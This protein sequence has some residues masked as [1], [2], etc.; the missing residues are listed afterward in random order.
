[1]GLK[2][3][4]QIPAR[5]CTSQRAIN[6][7]V[8]CVAGIACCLLGVVVLAVAA[9]VSPD[10][11]LAHLPSRYHIHNIVSLLEQFRLCDMVIGCILCLEGLIF[12]RFKDRLAG[13]CTLSPCLEKKDIWPEPHMRAQLLS[14]R[15]HRAIVLLIVFLSGFLAWMSL[16]PGHDWGGDFAA[17]I[18]Q[19]QDLVNGRP[20]RF[21]ADN[22]FTVTMS[23][24]PVGPLAYPWGFPVMLAGCMVFFGVNL[25]AFKG[26]ILLLYL[27]FL[28]VLWS[29]LRPRHTVWG[30]VLLVSLFAFNPYLIAFMNHILSDLPF[31]LVSTL[32]V[33]WIGKISREKKYLIAPAAD[34]I[35]LGL[36]IAV[37][38]FVRTNG[39]ILLM[40]LGVVHFTEMIT[41]LCSAGHSWLGRNGS[42]WRQVV[43]R[44]WMHHSE[45][46]IKLSPYLVFAFTVFLSQAFLPDGGSYDL[47]EEFQTLS[48]G[49]FLVHFLY[50]LQL[51]SEFFAISQFE[52]SRILFLFTVPLAV[53]GM[54]KRSSLDA[55]LLVYC[56]L[57]FGLYLVWP[58]LQGLRFLFP[59]LPFYLSFVISG[60]E[61]MAALQLKIRFQVHRLFI[62][63]LCLAL[64]S[65]F[66]ITTVQAGVRLQR[67]PREVILR[68]TPYSQASQDVFS[69]I[70]KTTAP[71]EVIVFFRPRVMRLLTSRPSLYIDQ[72]RFLHRGDYLCVNVNRYTL[73]SQDRLNDFLGQGLIKLVYENAAFK[74][75]QIQG[76]NG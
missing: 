73:F 59:V 21:V 57:T 58:A 7:H 42:V 52:L 5:C 74:L 24:Q 60:L 18:L 66:F 61:S 6:A 55:H 14:Q 70:Q 46:L 1:M 63:T 35:L 31:L 19:A 29:G 51:P 62:G 8:L 28:L 4:S 64:V 38:F 27:L 3:L 75:F 54:V 50:Y 40:V 23:T 43:Q 36:A 41:W 69:L 49:F 20:Q 15:E 13:L 30:H 65:A 25:L 17:Y 45:I 26:L 11:A 44:L 10:F 47:F 72:K 2:T 16:I 22:S 12:L 67:M 71:D 9:V 48:P 53:I 34:H 33:L 76:N 37:S 32:S 39:V 68:D 56:G